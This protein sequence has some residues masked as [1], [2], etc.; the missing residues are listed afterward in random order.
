VKNRKDPDDRIE[1]ISENVAKIFKKFP[2]QGAP[3][4][5]VGT[6]GHDSTEPHGEGR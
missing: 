2:T 1:D 5:P 4:A 6:T 3:I